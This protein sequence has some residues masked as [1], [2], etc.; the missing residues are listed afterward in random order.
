MRR[1]RV[2]ASGPSSPFALLA[3][4]GLDQGAKRIEAIRP[5]ARVELEPVLGVPERGRIEPIDAFPAPRFAGDEAGA[6]EYAEVFGDAGEGQAEGA[7]EVAYGGG[8]GV[9]R[10]DSASRC[11]RATSSPISVCGLLASGSRRSAFR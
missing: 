6:F 4:A 11:S 1:S 8:P 7:G 9:Q 10:C 5:E 3:G 2:E